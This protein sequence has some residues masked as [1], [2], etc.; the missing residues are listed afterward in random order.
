MEH[1]K[2]CIIDFLENDNLKVLAITGD[3]GVGKTYLWQKGVYEKFTI[4]QD[5]YSYVSLFNVETIS[6]LKTKLYYKLTP[7]KKE[8][9]R[10]YVPNHIELT[11]QTK[12]IIQ[13]LQKIEI[14]N[15][16]ICFDDI[17]RKSDRLDLRTFLGYVSELKEFNDSNNKILII[18]NYN[19][20][21]F[22]DKKTLDK[23]KEKIIDLEIIY[24]PKTNRNLE[25]LLAH[26]EKFS[27][28]SDEEWFSLFVGQLLKI[29]LTNI[30]L[31]LFICRNIDH[32]KNILAKNNYN[33][34]NETIKNIVNSIIFFNIIK[35]KKSD[36]N[37]AL[38]L[39][40]IR[41]LMTKSHR[42]NDDEYRKKSSIFD[43]YKSKYYF[44]NF[45][46][47]HLEI[48]SYIDNGYIENIEN[49]LQHFFKFN[50]QIKR[51]NFYNTIDHL[52]FKKSANFLLTQSEYISTIKNTVIENI[53]E[54]DLKDLRIPI[55]MLNE[56]NQNNDTTEILDI[57]IKKYSKIG[58]ES[59]EKES[60]IKLLSESEH[61]KLIETLKVNSTHEKAIDIS[62]FIYITTQNEIPNEYELER[63]KEL[64][65]EKVEYFLTH[66]EDR[67]L[68]NLLPTFL[69][70]L[71]RSNI[72]FDI[73]ILHK[74][75]AAL[76][77]ISQRSELDKQRVL[78]I[79]PNLF[80]E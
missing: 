3:W 71:S 5:F 20:M 4:Q 72:A 69:K 80:N 8:N 24:K 55:E 26:K 22:E 40:D 13:Q 34:H 52:K 21:N 18:F 41:E 33:I 76:K 36:D 63:L 60:L 17:E 79:A 10:K 77:N 59:Y 49:F 7:T 57:L 35:Y 6:E 43:S 47:Y 46:N 56:I 15:Y 9:S 50:Q 67:H 61:I 23:Y 73:E 54:L 70:T 11:N 27:F 68:L 39:N 1:I 28:T 44:S 37:E 42:L 62:H 66:T 14:N 32:L 12:N 38:D 19:E 29:E 65:T 53:S 64:N 74:F 45:S 48:L 25:I 75:K 78:M 2:Q 16:L 51:I 30:R 31:L 58:I